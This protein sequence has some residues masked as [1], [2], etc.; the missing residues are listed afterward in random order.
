MYDG[1]NKN[2]T[3]AILRELDSVVR[4]PGGVRASSPARIGVRNG[5]SHKRSGRWQTTKESKRTLLF[6]VDGARSL[7]LELGADLIEQLIE[8]SVWRRRWHANRGTMR[9]VHRALLQ[10]ER[11]AQGPSCSMRK[12]ILGAEQTGAMR[13]GGDEYALC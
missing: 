6:I 10:P 8:A 4:S 1:K 2:N 9:V 3:N 13:S 12:R 7:T 11:M 5:S